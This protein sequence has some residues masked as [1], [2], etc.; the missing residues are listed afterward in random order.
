MTAGNNLNKTKRIFGVNL[1]HANLPNNRTIKNVLGNNPS[2]VNFKKII[3]NPKKTILGVNLK[4]ANLPNNRS[5]KNVLG[6]NLSNINSKK[7]LGNQKK[8]VLGVNLKHIK[9][10]NNMTLKNSL[11]N[12][13]INSKKILRKTTPEYK[14]V[15]SFKSAFHKAIKEYYSKEQTLLINIFFKLSPNTN[16]RVYREIQF[17]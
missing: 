2:N 1:K 11:G 4:H 12:T 13:I 7:I 3:G 6:N 16:I 14:A 8:T 5:I 9:P 10:P 15:N 17:I